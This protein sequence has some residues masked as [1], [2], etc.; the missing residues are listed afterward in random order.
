MTAFGWWALMLAKDPD[1]WAA[2]LAGEPVDP[3]TLDPKF[4]ARASALQLVRLDVAAVD[5]WFRGV[6]S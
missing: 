6:A 5:Y 2:L 3:G 4:L 1:T